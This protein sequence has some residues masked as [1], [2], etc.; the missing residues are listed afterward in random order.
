MNEYY[1]ESPEDIVKTWF[2]SHQNSEQTRVSIL[3]AGDD[4]YVAVAYDVDLGDYSPV[5][6]ELIAF[7]PTLEG[8]HQRA[9]RWMERN[10][11]GV[12]YQDGD[13]SGDGGGG[14]VVS[15]LKRL[16]KNVN[17]YGNQQM[18]DIQ[19]QGGKQ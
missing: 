11:K 7:D 12:A 9:T 5:A 17:D 8:A 19:Q 4:A 3:S 13:E 14:K 16:A 6:A 10:P 15:V 1:T 18:E 2:R